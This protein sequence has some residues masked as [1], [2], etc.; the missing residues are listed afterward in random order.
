MDNLQ[1]SCVPTF[2]ELQR[3]HRSFI[4]GFIHKKIGDREM[5]EDLTQEVLT[6]VYFALPRYRPDGP[7]RA[8]LTQIA[9]NHIATYWRKGK[10]STL[11]IEV[12]EGGKWRRFEVLSDEPPVSKRFEDHELSDMI[13]KAMSRLPAKLKRLFLMKY[14]Q[15]MTY[16][17]IADIMDIPEAT[18]RIWAFRAKNRLRDLLEAA[19]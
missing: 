5:A 10:L 16:E 7:I 2:D 17:E 14:E 19:S 18:A 15:E 1:T 6:K 8:W 3:E 11:P 13:R 9:K 4:F 12:Y